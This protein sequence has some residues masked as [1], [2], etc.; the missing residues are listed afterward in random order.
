MLLSTISLRE[1]INGRKSCVSVQTRFGIENHIYFLHINRRAWETYH[2][3]AW[4]RS[5]DV[6]RMWILGGR[7]Y[8]NVVCLMHALEVLSLMDKV[9]P[10]DALG[11]VLGLMHVL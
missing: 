6:G 3:E 11:E 2:T 8:A 10:A 5:N 9:S 1:V 7:E 4:W